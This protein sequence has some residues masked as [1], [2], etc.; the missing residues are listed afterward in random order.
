MRSMN[1]NKDKISCRECRHYYITWE[2]DFPNACRVMGFKAK[3]MPDRIAHQTSG[4][5][6]Q[7][8]APK[9]PG[10]ENKRR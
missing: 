9:N 4:M 7:L 6:C 3:T 5:V 1:N 10:D 8:F 2:Q